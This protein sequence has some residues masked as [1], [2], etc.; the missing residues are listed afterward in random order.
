MQGKGE[1]MRRV[2][3][4]IG[5]YSRDGYPCREE[6][7][8][9]GLGAGYPESSRGQVQVHGGYGEKA[10]ESRLG[11]V[12]HKPV[13]GLFPAVSVQVYSTLRGWDIRTKDIVCVWPGVDVSQPETHALLLVTYHR[14]MRQSVKK[15]DR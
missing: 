6:K 3:S 10:H 5:T 2:E 1:K 11:G 12:V 8:R 14:D 13:F 15:K 9:V 7:T 4:K